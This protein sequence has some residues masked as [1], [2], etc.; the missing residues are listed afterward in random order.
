MS[1]KGELGKEVSSGAAVKTSVCVSFKEV[2]VV[3]WGD[4]DWPVTSVS[5]CVMTKCGAL[6]RLELEQLGHECLHRQEKQVHI[7]GISVA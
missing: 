7:G 6:G 3:D 2:G 5:H 1:K 4:C